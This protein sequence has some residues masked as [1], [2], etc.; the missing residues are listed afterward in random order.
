VLALDKTTLI[1]ATTD[2]GSLQL[3]TIQ[4]GRQ[5]VR[6]HRDE[7]ASAPPTPIGVRVHRGL[8]ISSVFSL[9]GTGADQV[10]KQSSLTV[11]AAIG[12]RPSDIVL[13][14]LVDGEIRLA[15]NVT[16]G[17]I[18]FLLR[19]SPTSFSIT[20]KCAI[21]TRIGEDDLTFIGGLEVQPRGASIVTTMKG[22]WTGAFG[23]AGLNIANVALDLGLSFA[24]LLPTLGVAGTVTV[25][26]V[27]GS[28]AVR[29]DSRNPAYSM[30]QVRLERLYLLDI[31]STFGG[32]QLTS[33]LPESTRVLLSQIGI[34]DIDLH[35]AP[36]PT[37]IGDLDFEQ[38]LN[39]AGRLTIQSF[40]AAVRMKVDSSG[41]IL[42]KGAITPIELAGLFSVTGNRVDV[43]PSLDFALGQG[44]P[45]AMTIDGRVSLLGI[46]AR[47]LIRLDQNG[48]EFE[49]SGPIFGV[50]QA[51]VTARGG[52]IG[53]S[54]GFMLSA[55]M[56][57]D[58]PAYLA[59]KAGR[60]ISQAADT[61]MNSLSSA[62]QTLA[63]EEQKLQTIDVLIE[64][65]RQQV[66]SRNYANLTKAI[67]DVA[68]LQAEVNRLDGVVI[69]QR[70]AAEDGRRKAQTDLQAAIDRVENAQ[71]EVQTLQKQINDQKAWISTL[72][73]RIADKQRWV[74][75]SS[76]WDKIP[77]GLEFSAF[78][79]ARGAEITVAY[80]KIGGLAAGQEI[81]WG[82]L[83]GA[84][85]FLRTAR[86][87]ANKRFDELNLAIQGP[88]GLQAAAY[89]ALNVAQ[90]GLAQ[91]RTLSSDTLVD[92]DPSVS[93]LIALR[94]S[95]TIG[96]ETAR[97]SLTIAQ[98]AVGG[99]ADVASFVVSNGLN[100]LID[101]R[102]A[103]FECSL[104]SGQAGTVDL[105]LTIA[106]MKAP[107]QTMRLSFNFHDPFAGARELARRLTPG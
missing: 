6:L 5:D 10:L 65:A 13:E 39:I 84:N 102:S 36:M 28:A 96:L 63:A 55:R 97:S 85:A 50:F 41:G 106:F 7:I 76:F 57:N 25:G 37:R 82:V 17:E 43:G 35:V 45:F 73:Q 72:K 34:E 19:P 61:A 62:Q 53:S 27:T 87:A 3:S 22:Q 44:A 8:N 78:S 21:K 54:V 24:P 4:P 77:N 105:D 91:L 32:A 56:S 51:T 12:T 101:I 64:R 104:I 71:R 81:A 95:A 49:V 47:A 107:A 94:Q 18:G 93:G 42:A 90:L 33:D 31:V 103:G 26:A 86:E 30:V 92:L 100:G 15:D 83:E 74:D 58:L 1:V 38:G 16:M 52:E 48:F 59:D 20:L 2:D 14:A 68:R 46:F 88:L 40:V 98:K 11:F 66:R 29:F 70:A 67:A 79:A 75:N 60:I 9:A 80:T 89:R 23:V 99:L 69:Q